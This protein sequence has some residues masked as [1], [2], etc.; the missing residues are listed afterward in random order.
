M[1][2]TVDGPAAAGKGE[3]TQRLAEHFDYARLD[4]GRLYRAVGLAVLVCAAASSSPR[5]RAALVWFLS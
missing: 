3:L 4:T 5:A 2:I 1:I